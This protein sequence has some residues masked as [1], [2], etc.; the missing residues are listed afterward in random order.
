MLRLH[1]NDESF[2]GND[3]AGC[4]AS[5]VQSKQQQQKVEVFCHLQNNV[6]LVICNVNN[7]FCKTK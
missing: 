7:S 3:R 6:S 4:F 5:L 1:A 2:V